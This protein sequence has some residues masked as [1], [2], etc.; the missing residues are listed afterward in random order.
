MQCGSAVRK[1]EALLS[2]PLKNYVRERRHVLDQSYRV[3]PTVPIRSDPS[4]NQ[5]R[6]T[7]HCPICF[8]PCTRV[9][10]GLNRDRY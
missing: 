6:F 1:I 10:E 4:T 2:Q 9:A 5:A 3:F 8:D 7:L